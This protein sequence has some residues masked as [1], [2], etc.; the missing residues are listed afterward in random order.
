MKEEI[1]NEEEMET[2]T[3][4]TGTV[5]RDDVMTYQCTNPACKFVINFI[6]G[7]RRIKCP[8]CFREYEIKG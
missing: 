1:L 7:R 5:M 6:A 3:G 4:G 8:R 2:V